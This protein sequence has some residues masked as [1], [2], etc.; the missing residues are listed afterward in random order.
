[1]SGEQDMN[2]PNLITMTPQNLV[3]PLPNISTALQ[4]VPVADDSLWCQVNGWIQSNT[5]V[6]IVILIGA[7]ALAWGRSRRGR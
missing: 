6:S 5:G 7:A 4:P 3:A 1:M 2:F